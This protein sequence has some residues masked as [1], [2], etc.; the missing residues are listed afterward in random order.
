MSD[1]EKNI[2]GQLSNIIPK[3]DK[4][5]QNYILGVAD[6]MAIASIEKKETQPQE[7]MA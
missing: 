1:K 7:G 5:K 4:D 6:G 3:L 2:I